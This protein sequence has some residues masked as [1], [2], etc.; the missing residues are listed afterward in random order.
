MAR[1]KKMKVVTFSGM[2]PDNSSRKLGDLNFYVPAMTYGIAECS[3]QILL[4]AWL[5]CF[6]KVCEWDLNPA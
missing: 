2:K 1:Q 4:H 6:M 5:D 3:H